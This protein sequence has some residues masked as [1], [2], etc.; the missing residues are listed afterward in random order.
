MTKHL[1]SLQICF[2]NLKMLNR[3]K[4]AA[5]QAVLATTIPL[6]P[7]AYWRVKVVCFEIYYG[8]GSNELKIQSNDQYHKQTKMSFQDI[9][10]PSG[11]DEPS[12]ECTFL[13]FSHVHDTRHFKAFLDPVGLFQVVDE[14]VLHTNMPTVH[15]L[16]TTYWNYLAINLLNNSTILLLKLKRTC[17]LRIPM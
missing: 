5:I 13:I 2:Y 17:I 7:Q 16:Y 6:Q 10:L 9:Y 8:F 15:S 3:Q 11:S 12:H 4:W 14:H 1:S